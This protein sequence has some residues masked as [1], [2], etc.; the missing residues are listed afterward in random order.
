MKNYSHNKTT[1]NKLTIKGV[2][3]KDCTTIEYINDDKETSTIA[4]EKC[5]EFF[6]GEPIVLSVGMKTDEDLLEDD[7][8]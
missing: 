6:A 8:F 7:E 5:L 4:V 2:L 1:T 3:S